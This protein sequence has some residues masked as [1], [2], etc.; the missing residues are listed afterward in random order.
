M[1]RQA[2]LEDTMKYLHACPIGRTTKNATA[3]CMRHVCCIG[4]SNTKNG[5]I[6]CDIEQYLFKFQAKCYIM[7]SCFHSN[8]SNGKCSMYSPGQFLV[9]QYCL[10]ICMMVRNL[11]LFSK[12]HYAF[13][14]PI[15]NCENNKKPRIPCPDRL[16]FDSFLFILT[17]A[18]QE[19]LPPGR[20]HWLPMWL[21]QAF[22]PL[23][24]PKPVSSLLLLIV[25]NKMTV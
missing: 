11:P 5:T 20:L 21:D 14:I 25:T 24:T 19:S 7:F 2:T 10:I 9:I 8:S 18:S 15:S 13:L 23:C 4:H 6:T 3:E 22:I 1:L 12:Y 16:S 17:D